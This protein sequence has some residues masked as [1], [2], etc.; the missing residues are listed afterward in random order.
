MKGNE[1]LAGSELFQR[2]SLSII[3]EIDGQSLR[4]KTSR[5]IVTE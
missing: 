2:T 4:E 5:N 1:H 3:L